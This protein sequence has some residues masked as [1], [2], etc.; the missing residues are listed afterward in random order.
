MMVY[1][2]VTKRSIE[3]YWSRIFSEDVGRLE[4]DKNK[5]LI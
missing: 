5:K 2:G 4:Q 1:D 3:D